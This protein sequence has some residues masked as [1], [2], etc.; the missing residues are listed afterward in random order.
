MNLMAIFNPVVLSRF[1][2]NLIDIGQV[3]KFWGLMGESGNISK[4]QMHADAWGIRKLIS[5]TL[6]SLRLARIPRER[7]LH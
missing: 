4:N 3:Q 2:Q 1:P 7:R 5:H 6:R